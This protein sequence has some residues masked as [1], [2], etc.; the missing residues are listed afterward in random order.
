MRPIENMR[1]PL[2]DWYS[3]YKIRVIGTIVVLDVSGSSYCEEVHLPMYECRLHIGLA[4]PDVNNRYIRSSRLTVSYGFYGEGLRLLSMSSPN[5]RF[6]CKDCL[7]EPHVT[8]V[9]E[10]YTCECGKMKFPWV[11]IIDC[12]TM[13]QTSLE[14]FL[15]GGFYVTAEF[16]RR[17]YKEELIAATMNPERKDFLASVLDIEELKDFGI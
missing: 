8:M 3:E 12:R 2:Q 9:V 6:S 1:T 5:P 14:R 16:N 10:D 4:H 17:P 7:D 13:N 11:D 15:P